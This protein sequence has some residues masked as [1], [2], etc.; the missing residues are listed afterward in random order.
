MGLGAAHQ[1]RKS[2]QV[3]GPRARD[4]GTR[5]R[6][7]GTDCPGQVH[8]VGRNVGRPVAPAFSGREVTA[9]AAVLGLRPGEPG[10]QPVP[11]LGPGGE[12]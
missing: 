1:V 12:Q 3:P 5:R 4:L 2:T 8:R 9:Q 11:F 6:Y 10:F 7:R